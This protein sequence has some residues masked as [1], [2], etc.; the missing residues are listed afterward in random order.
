MFLVPDQI[1]NPLRMILGDIKLGSLSDAIAVLTSMITPALLISASGTFILSTSTRLTTVIDRVRAI[2][3]KFEGFVRNPENEPFFL[4][5]REMLLEQMGR[6][7]LR[8]SL[9]QRGLTVLYVAAGLFIASSVAIG[10]VAIFRFTAAWIPVV[11][12]VSGASLL[13]YGCMLLIV[14]ARLAVSTLNSET[15][16]LVKMVTN[17]RRSDADTASGV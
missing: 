12:G 3:E 13:F 15:A 2:S 14:E 5:Q 4:E 8:A 17:K 11:L 6:L 10:L 9:L 1:V 16:F 7:S